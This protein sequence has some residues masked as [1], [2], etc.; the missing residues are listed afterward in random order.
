MRRAVRN[1]DVNARIRA[2]R[3]L[4]KGARRGEWELERKSSDADMDKDTKAVQRQEQ[5]R[6]EA[7]EPNGLA[8]DV[9]GL[10]HSRER[11]DDDD[12]EIVQP[13]PGMR[14]RRYDMLK[15]IEEAWAE[16]EVDD[17]TAVELD[18]RVGS[19]RKYVQAPKPLVR[20]PME[21]K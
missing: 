15:E 2:P 20:E 7:E 11:I 16:T 12:D 9:S 18:R 6:D 10:E 19:T 14:K 1:D 3:A 21:L 17:E 5:Q 8:S 13:A 4:K